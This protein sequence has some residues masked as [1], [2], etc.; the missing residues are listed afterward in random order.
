MSL[1]DCN[2]KC[3]DE[4]VSAAVVREHREDSVM[5]AHDEVRPLRKS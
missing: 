1:K 2:A 4:Y 5:F 3:V